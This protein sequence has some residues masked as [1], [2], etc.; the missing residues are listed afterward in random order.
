MTNYTLEQILVFVMDEVREIK[1]DI[2]GEVENRHAIRLVCNKW[3]VDWF[4]INGKI[5][6]RWKP[7]NA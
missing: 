6:L 5:V 2:N 1:V 4:L 3:G 7:E